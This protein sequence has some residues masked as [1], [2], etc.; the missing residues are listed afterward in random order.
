MKE[1]SKSIVLPVKHDES[2]SPQW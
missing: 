2:V 1:S